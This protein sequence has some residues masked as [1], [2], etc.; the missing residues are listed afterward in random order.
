MFIF[1]E[2]CQSLGR[3]KMQNLPCNTPFFLVFLSHPKQ[4]KRL[5][6]EN[7][8]LHGKWKVSLDTLSSSTSGSSMVD[9]NSRRSSAVWSWGMSSWHMNTCR[10]FAT[11][12]TL[13]LSSP[14]IWMISRNQ[15]HF[16]DQMYSAGPACKL[17]MG[18][19][20]YGI[21]PSWTRVI[22]A[23]FSCTSKTLIS[24]QIWHFHV[25]YIS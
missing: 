25:N 21:R 4:L 6:K 8:H 16:N 14:K 12:W 19:L 24:L 13:S 17:L 11:F 23:F 2:K 3:V 5:K 7:L 22:V 10:T 15:G 20:H 18:C 1:H 9:T